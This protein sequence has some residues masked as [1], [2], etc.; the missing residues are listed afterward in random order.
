LNRKAK[1]KAWMQQHVHDPYVQL[2]VAGG[3]R[4]RAAYKLIEIDHRDRLMRPGQTVIDLGAAPG[5]WSQVIVERVTP[6]GRVI[7][8]DMLPIEP[9]A[10]VTL[11]EG[12]FRDGAVLERLEQALGVRQADL[13]VSD[14]AP[15]L[16]GVSASD[17]A[18]ASHL[19]ELA[20][21]FARAHLKPNGALLVK[22]FQGAGYPAFLADMR[23]SFERV[24]SRKP[25]ASRGRSAEM[26][27]L[28]RTLKVDPKAT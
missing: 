4:S 11:I 26:Y 19:C 16:S 18:R 7:A 1:S 12:D 2:A 23:R 22:A 20:L 14:M 13:V 5:S 28:G 24:V 6:G 3:Y 21:E 9:I 27:L 8:L 25:G 15:N 10:G 17:Q